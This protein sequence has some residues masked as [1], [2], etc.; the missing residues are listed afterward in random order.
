MRTQ[1]KATI[2]HFVGGH[3]VQTIYHDD[4]IKTEVKRINVQ[5]RKEGNTPLNNGGGWSISVSEKGVSIVV[6]YLDT[7]GDMCWHYLVL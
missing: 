2:G 6:E 4:E 5:L 7:N 1:E 3:N